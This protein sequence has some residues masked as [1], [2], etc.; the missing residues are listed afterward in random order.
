MKK[1]LDQLNDG[2]IKL[3]E[4][5]LSDGSKAYNVETACALE[6]ACCDSTEAEDLFVEMSGHMTEVIQRQGA[7]AERIKQDVLTELRKKV[8]DK[9]AD[10]DQEARVW[11]EQADKDKHDKDYDSMG[12][13]I[14]NL[15]ELHKIN[16]GLRQTR[17]MIDVMMPQ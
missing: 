14:T 9:I 2:R 15:L 8:S 11:A 10:N 4:E 17:I 1:T 6:F 16:D 13:C 5:T 3:I 12:R 7:I